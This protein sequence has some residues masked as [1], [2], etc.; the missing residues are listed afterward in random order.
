MRILIS[1]LTTLLT[2]VV[3]ASCGSATETEGEFNLSAITVNGAG[4]S[5]PAPI[6]ETWSTDFMNNTGMQ[7]NY[8]SVGSGAGIAQ[9]TAK[10]VNFGASDKPLKKEELD[11]EGLIQFPMIIGGIVP[12]VNLPGLRAG[13]LKLTPDL[14]V[15]I[16]L[17]KITKWNDSAITAVNPG[18]EL[19]DMDITVVHRSD[20]S[21][22]TW[23]FTNYLCKVSSEWEEKIGNDKSVEW[24]GDIGAKGNEGV[25][26]QVKQLEGTIGYVEYAYSVRNNLSFARLRNKAGNFVEP[27]IENVQAAAANADWSNAPG[28]YMVLTDQPGADSWPL[29]GASFILLHKEQPNADIAKGMLTF[30]DWCFRNGS[31]SAVGLDYIPIPENVYKMVEETWSKD[32][33][34]VG[35]PVWTTE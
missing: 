2:V 1:I 11:A 28:Y 13:E 9:I 20:G 3:I 17:K 5:F 32:V 14:L 24:V 31:E 33:M 34:S 27:K 29:T 12:I 19:P 10:T 35:N 18:L 8:Q 23:I 21:G 16:Y 15:D 6:Y 30:F 25:A 22:S 4:A 26:N 7:V